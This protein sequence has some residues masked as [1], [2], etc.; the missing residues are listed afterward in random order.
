NR[1]DTLEL[2]VASASSGVDLATKI[3]ANCGAKV[4]N[5]VK[6]PSTATDFLPYLTNLQANLASDSSEKSGLYV[7]IFGAPEITAF[8]EGVAL[9]LLN[10]YKVIFTNVNDID[11]VA[12]ALGSSMP[13]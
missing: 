9:G 5:R 13:P 3:F 11:L 7:W 4:T 8:K 10:K 6:V 2:N 1:I 12:N